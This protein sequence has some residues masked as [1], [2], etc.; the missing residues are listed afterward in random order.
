M[1]KR[2]KILA[3]I[4]AAC[5]MFTLA[6]P[7]KAFAAEPE[8]ITIESK[9]NKVRYIRWGRARSGNLLLPIIRIMR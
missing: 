5:M 9:N 7:G 1:I 6:V 4:L 2:K 3:A 8:E